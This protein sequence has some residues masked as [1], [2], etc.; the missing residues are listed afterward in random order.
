MQKRHGDEGS[1]T[2][3]QGHTKRLI[4][5]HQAPGR[6]VAQFVMREL[7]YSQAN[8]TFDQRGPPS[9]GLNPPPNRDPGR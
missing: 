4:W 1:R 8:R 9:H 2:A 5:H 6:L 7:C 3:P